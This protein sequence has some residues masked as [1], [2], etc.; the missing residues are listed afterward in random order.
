M[1]TENDPVVF[2]VVGLVSPTIVK[3]RAAIPPTPTV[4]FIKFVTFTTYIEIALHVTGVIPATK[5]PIDPTVISVGMVICRND[6]VFR[7]L[8]LVIVRV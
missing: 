3:G 1:V 2:M 5:H 4:A 8:V 6:P 7:L